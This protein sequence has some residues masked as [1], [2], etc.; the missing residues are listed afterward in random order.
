VKNKGSA[1]QR[2]RAFGRSINTPAREGAMH[3][4][5][6]CGMT[7]DDDI[8]MEFRY[9]ATCEGDYEYCMNHLKVHEHVKKEK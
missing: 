6:V 2:G 4:C 9:C 3:K 8:T 1:Y 5:T 7:E